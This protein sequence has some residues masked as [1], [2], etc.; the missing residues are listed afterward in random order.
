MPKFQINLNVPISK[1][2]K[3]ITF[4]IPPFLNLNLTLNLNFV[5]SEFEAFGGDESKDVIIKGEDHQKDDQDQTDLLG[6]L[7]LFNADRFPENRFEDQEDEMASVED[8]DGEEGDDPEVDAQDGHEEDQT[9]QPS[10]GL[11]AGQLSNQD[12]APDG[13]CRDDPLDQFPNGNHRQLGGAPSLSKSHAYGNN[14][15]DFLNDHII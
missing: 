4:F 11:F 14:G 5:S 9:C 10:L 13:L 12:G 8:R 1:L 2:P 3:E 7:H 15:I 6:N